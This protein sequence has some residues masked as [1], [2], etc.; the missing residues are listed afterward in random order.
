M[1]VLLGFYVLGRRRGEGC[2]VWGSY[3][4]RLLADVYASLRLYVVRIQSRGGG[5]PF[6]VRTTED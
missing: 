2:P 4:G 5:V 1:Y 3:Q 6:K